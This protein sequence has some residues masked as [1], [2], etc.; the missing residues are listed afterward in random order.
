MSLLLVFS[1]AEGAK[2]EGG[3]SASRPVSSGRSVRQPTTSA[4]NGAA[5]IVAARVEA[6]ELVELRLENERLRQQLE[7]E[8]S[9]VLP[10]LQEPPRLSFAADKP[11]GQQELLASLFGRMASTESG[12]GEAHSIS[13]FLV[14]GATLDP[15][16]KSKIWECAYIELESLGSPVEFPSR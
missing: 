12:E 6:Y 8:P 9:M 14:L 13:P 3:G 11:S 1:H 7:D 16:I 4:A 5:A 15:K 2:R 10:A